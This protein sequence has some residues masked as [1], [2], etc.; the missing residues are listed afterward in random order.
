MVRCEGQAPRQARAG[1]AAIKVSR[2][3]IVARPAARSGRREI[4]YECPHRASCRSPSPTGQ[5]NEIAPGVCR[6]FVRSS[7]RSTSRVGWRSAKTASRVALLACRSGVRTFGAACGCR[8]SLACFIGTLAAVPGSVA[9][10]AHRL[11]A[12]KDKISCRCRLDVRPRTSRPH[13]QSFAGDVVA[14]CSRPRKLAALC[15]S[16]QRRVFCWLAR[17]AGNLC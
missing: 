14:A 4:L 10:L 2:F 8:A 9:M 15:R 1:V 3:V 17:P 13:P 11:L 7:P 16:G 5:R 12:A 6:W